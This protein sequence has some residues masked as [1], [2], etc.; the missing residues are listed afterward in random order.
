MRPFS[1]DSQ[2]RFDVITVYY[3]RNSSHPQ[4]QLF[5]NAIPSP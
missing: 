5:Q 2:W 4:F 3:D 1:P